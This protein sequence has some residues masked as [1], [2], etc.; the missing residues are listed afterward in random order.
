MKHYFSLIFFVLWGL[1]VSAQT[2]QKRT[3]KFYNI[4]TSSGPATFDLEMTVTI[5]DALNR[6]TDGFI[7]DQKGQIAL[8][9]KS[10]T[11]DGIILSQTVEQHQINEKYELTR[12]GRKY[13]L[14]SYKL[15]EGT[16]IDENSFEA[17]EIVTGPSLEVHLQKNSEKLKTQNKLFLEFGIFELLKGLNFVVKKTEKIFKDENTNLALQLM[18]KSMF[19]SMFADPLYIEVDPV[20]FALKKY[21]GRTPVRILKNG[22]F[23]PYDADIYYEVK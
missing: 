17:D 9:E 21:R 1:G 2:I 4:G 3:A 14:K 22:K 10:E 12:E 19:L 15:K 20:N 18:V 5:Q 8:K 6:K 7:K 23:V 16:L 11:K 13:S